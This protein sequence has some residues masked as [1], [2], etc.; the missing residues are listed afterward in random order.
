MDIIIDLA[1]DTPKEDGKGI[2]K[3]VV[4]VLK[5][6]RWKYYIYNTELNY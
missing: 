4:Y 3:F 2:E 1:E 5:N 6:S